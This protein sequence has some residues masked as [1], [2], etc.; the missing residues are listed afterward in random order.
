MES[1]EKAF[2]SKRKKSIENIKK[3]YEIALKYGKNYL[4]VSFSGG[5]DSQTLYHLAEEAA[6]PFIARFLLTTLDPPEVLKF[7]HKHY[8]A[9]RFV[10]PTIGFWELCKKKK[11]MPGRTRRF[12]CAILKESTGIG[13]VNLTGVRWEES[14]RRATRKEISLQSGRKKIEQTI[15]QFN[16]TQLVES[17]CIMGKGERIVVNP[18]L[19]WSQKDVWYYLNEVKK[20]PHCSLYDKG[21]SRVGCI[22]CPMANVKDRVRDALAYPHF[23]KM[24]K[25]T[26]CTVFTLGKER[27]CKTVE[28][29]IEWLLTEEHFSNICSPL[30]LPKESPLSFSVD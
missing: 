10:R 28:H 17:S 26:A 8:P 5:K 18:I 12:C 3:A 27:H 19:E 9:V 14:S 1:F 13:E 24:Y 30:L 11:S 23:W 29:Y 6:V 7:V 25:R 15:D 4:V 2:L 20:V 16:R 21:W 22:L